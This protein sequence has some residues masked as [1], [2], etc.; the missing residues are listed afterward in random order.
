M[1]FQSQ[2]ALD[3]TKNNLKDTLLQP[4]SKDLKVDNTSLLQRTNSLPI[5]RINANDTIKANQNIVLKDTVVLSFLKYKISHSADSSIFNVLKIINYK[6]VKFDGLIETKLPEGWHGIGLP[7]GK[8]SIEPGDSFFI[9]FRLIE[10]NKVY[11][12]QAYV[13]TSFLKSNKEKY[14]GT[15]FIDV[16]IKSDWF[17]KV[18]SNTIYF[19]ELYDLKDFKILLSNKG[20]VSELIKLTFE[21]GKLLNLIGFNELNNFVYI[22]LPAGSDTILNYNVSYKKELIN[23]ES[24]LDNIERETTLRVIASNGKTKRE[25]IQFR[26]VRSY[27]VLQKNQS[28]SPLNFNLQVGNLLSATQPFIFGNVYGSILFTK[29]RELSYLFGLQNQVF[30]TPNINTGTLIQSLPLRINYKEPKYN[31]SVGNLALNNSFG[32]II[33]TGVVAELNLIKNNVF[34]IGAVK[35]LSPNSNFGGHGSYTPENDKHTNYKK[36]IILKHI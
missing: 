30:N 21:A 34:K 26:K 15:F 16:P 29:K 20:N 6:K 28:Q 9:P 7:M 4:I 27:F 5:N 17:M 12:G 1:S 31:I 25:T 22:S 23:N 14:F 32:G 36:Y 13:I 18:N 19:N 3:S 33:G 2:T 10:P 8:V 11:G 35:N 24:Y